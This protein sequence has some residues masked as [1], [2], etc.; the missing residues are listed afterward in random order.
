MKTQN[1]V[2]NENSSAGF[3][4]RLV[5]DLTSYSDSSLGWQSTVKHSKT[6]IPIELLFSV[7]VET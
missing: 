3:M 5:V 1:N 7:R 2:L 4:S 6:K